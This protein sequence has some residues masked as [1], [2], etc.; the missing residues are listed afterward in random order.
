MRLQVVNCSG[1]D[2]CLRELAYGVGDAALNRRRHCNHPELQ[3]HQRWHDR[4][5]D[6]IT[7]GER[8]DGDDR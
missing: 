2:G 5:G 7:D 8:R 1:P 6:E 3:V 4:G